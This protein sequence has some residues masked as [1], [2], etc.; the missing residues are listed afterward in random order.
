MVATPAAESAT[1]VRSVWRND[2]DKPNVSTGKTRLIA[3][4]SYPARTDR[5]RANNRP[6]AHLTRSS[7]TMK[8]ILHQPPSLRRAKE[9]TGRT[10]KTEQVNNLYR[11]ETD[12]GFVRT[13][14]GAVWCFHPNRT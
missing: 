8:S 5:R 11:E 4:S 14:P 1:V 6:I 2:C 3:R 12:P 9:I 7:D 10:S 13:L